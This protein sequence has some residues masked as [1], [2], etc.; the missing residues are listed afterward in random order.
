MW[1]TDDTWA[2]EIWSGPVAFKEIQPT[3]RA[4]GRHE[5]L[6]GIQISAIGQNKFPRQVS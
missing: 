6:K 3:Y 1:L 5:G 4:S 2:L